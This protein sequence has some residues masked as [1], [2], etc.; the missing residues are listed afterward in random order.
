M[1]S[2]SRTERWGKN[3]FGDEYAKYLSDAELVNEL[4]FACDHLKVLIDEYTKRS[5]LGSKKV[6]V[7]YRNAAKAIG[8]ALSI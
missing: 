4:D 6:E 1:K 3:R 8:T 7:A 5:M 2:V